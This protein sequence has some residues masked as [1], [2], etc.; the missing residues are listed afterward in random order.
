MSL[1][2]FS[3]SSSKG[4]TSSGST[5]PVPYCSSVSSYPSGITVTG[6]AQYEYR[7]NGNGPVASPL[8]IRYAEIRVTNSEG[9]IIQCGETDASGNFSLNL[10]SGGTATIVVAS[11]ADNNFVKAYVLNN[12]TNNAYYGI[13]VATSL[14]GNKSVGT[15]TAQATGDLFGA[16]FNILDKIVDSN[17]YLRTATANCGTTFPCTAF[18]VAPL[19]SAFWAKGKDPGEYFGLP[20]LSFFL[21]DNNQLYILGGKN[22]DVDSSDTDHFD[23]TIIIHEYGHF[24]EHNFSIANSPGGNHNGDNI[25]DPRLAWSEAWANYFQ[26]EVTGL[27]R[28]RDTFG[29]P[30]GTSGVLIN[31][32]LESG[33]GDTPTEMGEGNFREFSITRAL[34]DLT[35]ANESS[36]SDDLEASFEEIWTLFNN[37]SNAFRDTTQRFRS[38]G[39]FHILQSTLAGRTNWTT[40]QGAENQIVAR[41]NYANTLSAGTGCPTAILAQNVPNASV[42]NGPG[43][44]P[45]DGTFVNSNLFKSNDFY[46]ISHG[47]GPLTIS[48]TY[49]T[50]PGNAADLDLYL[51]N[52]SYVFGIASTVAGLSEDTISI[53]AS[54]DTETISLG[55]LAAGT[56]LLNV[57]YNT[58]GGIRST[59][60]YSLSLNGAGVCPD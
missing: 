50:T 27:P 4:A 44:Q 9:S 7:V 49:T 46:Q 23:N 55:S 26:A 60:N 57:N 19:V 32:N 28:Y 30:E 21:P 18:T 39:L 10:P 11:R 22:G 24:I 34:V 15:L 51:Y 53:A 43:R 1:L 48:M 37:T 2:N 52:E 45:E 56:Y 42:S 33:T 35:D 58:G 36:A 6:N 59:A 31:E 38:V 17:N 13:S 25:L 5:P 29:T 12:P 14:D 8:P 40:V 54:G 41:T 20:P 47:G 16:A 3:C